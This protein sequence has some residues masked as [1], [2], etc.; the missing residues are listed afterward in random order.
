MNKPIYNIPKKLEVHW[1]EDVK[2][3]IDTW[4]SYFISLQ[5]FSDAVLV[6]GLN[7]AK[8]NGAVAWIVDSSKAIGVF[9][10]EIQEYIG[11]DIFPAFSKN[12]IKYFITI[13]ADSYFTKKTIENYSAKTGPN[14]LILVEVKNVQDAIDFLKKE[15]K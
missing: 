6:H 1:Q 7:H 3:I 5:D 12:G 2:A 4:S 9:S 10:K 14:G 15:A 11:S 8:A 13:T